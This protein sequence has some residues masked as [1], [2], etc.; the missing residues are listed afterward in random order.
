LDLV[1]C[2]GRDVVAVLFLGLLDGGGDHRIHGILEIA[3]AVD[4]RPIA[5]SG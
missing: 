2:G 1:A 3:S 4:G 5:S